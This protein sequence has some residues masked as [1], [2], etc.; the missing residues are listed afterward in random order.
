MNTVM[1]QF[2]MGTMLLALGACAPAAAEDIVF[3]HG[4]IYTGN[5]QSPWAE[6]LAV[7]G[8]RIAAVGANK[9]LLARFR[10]HSRI[11]DLKG[12]TVIPGVID[13]HIHTL[14][15]AFALHGFDLSTPERSIPPDQPALLIELI[16]AYAAAHPT[17]SVLFGRADFSTVPPS[18]PSHELLDR[19]VS[20]RPIVI[21]NTSGHAYWLNAAALAAAGIGDYPVADAEEEGGVIRDASGHPS[22]VLLEASME[23]AAREILAKVPEA[24]QLAM[25]RAAI[26]YLNGYGITGVVNA[27]G[28]PREIGLFAT[29]RDRGELTVRTRTAFGAL[30]K[31]HHLTPEFLE[32]LDLARRTYHDEWVSANLVKFFTDGS[33]GL[34]PPLF[35]EPHE[36]ARLVAELDRRGYQIMTHTER[37]DGLHLI[38]DSYEQAERANGARDRRLRIEHVFLAYP[39]DL[40]RFKQLD[41][42]A[43]MQPSFCCTDNGSFNYKP[44]LLP[45]DQWKT[46]ELSGATLAFGSDWPCT[47]PPDPFVGIAEAT[48]RTVWRSRDLAAVVGQP[49]DGGAQAGAVATGEVF[50]PAERISVEQAVDAYTRGSAYAAFFDGWAGTLESGKLADLAVLSQD[51][52]SVPHEQIGRTRVV[53]T[54]VG[55]KVVYSATD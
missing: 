28:N 33:T 21:L 46:I 47:S 23:I 34:I 13:S 20:D 1:L 19:A 5:R 2:V 11:I 15:G 39:D 42:I 7:K 3:V 10:T 41:I 16:K 30:G 49:F 29:L 43:A 8:A 44:E 50:L 45:T 32:S 48:T 54:M 55:G 40:P 24:E 14:W 25:L 22:G 6:A 37:D 18:T 35:Y 27:T 31:R 36:Y 53:M 17:D 52:F 26:H 9:D 51:I 4:H 12:Q 38:L